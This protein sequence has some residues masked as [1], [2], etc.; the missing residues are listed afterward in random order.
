LDLFFHLKGGLLGGYRPQTEIWVR[1]A[2]RL[3]DGV[4]GLINYEFLDKAFH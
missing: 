2:G 1:K 4:G 3:K